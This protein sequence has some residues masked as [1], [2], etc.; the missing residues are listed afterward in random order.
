M[1]EVLIVYSHVR[2]PP[3]ATV[4]DSLCAFE[5]HSRARCWYLHLGVRRV[6][7]WLRRIPF[8]AVILHPTLLWDRDNP[9]RFEHHMRKLR[10]LAG[11]GRHRVA[12][13]QDEFLYSRSLVSL[14]RELDI[15]HVFSVAPES[16]WDQLYAGVD[17]E[18]VGIS[19]VLTG[20]LLPETVDRID[21]IVRTTSE[22]PIAIGYRAAR[23][24]PALGRHG[25]LKTEI[26]KRVGEAAEARGLPIDIAT[27][28]TGTI[29]GD[30]WY[31]FLASCRYT[32]GIEGGSSVHDP[33]GRVEQTTIRYLSEHPDALFE[34]VEANCFP[35]AD[36]GLRY[37]AI[38]PRHLEAC[39]TRTAQVLIEGSYNGILRPGEH[40]IELRRDFSNLD[41]V[42]DLIESD[43]E[44]ARLTEAAYRDVVASGAY[45]Y[46][47][48][49]REVEA[50]ALQDSK[51]RSA[52]LVVKALHR[53]IEITD[54]AAW[55]QVAVWV[56]VA[57]SLRPFAL[58]L[59]PASVLQFIRRRVAGTAAEVA[60]LQRA[61]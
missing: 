43:A 4:R 16:E 56:R 9:P 32:I 11:V 48:L 5:Q 50:V 21:E 26:A 39:A 51:A 15:D 23:L 27:G 19:R 61:E 52:S 36:G 55:V 46:E 31:R 44:R 13:P 25:L 14:I 24:L 40:Y 38:S 22:R 42:L 41:E 54:R 30:D 37:F 47:R 7:S 8:D 35:G 34:E 60:A 10:D 53:W 49:V 6:P 1:A 28:A 45:T 20:Y 59:F 57:S 12:M 58:R 3:T 18:R 33:D 17:R 29:R 2:W